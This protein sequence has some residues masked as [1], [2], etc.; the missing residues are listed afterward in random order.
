MTA[1]LSVQQLQHQLLHNCSAV[2]QLAAL[3][4]VPGVQRRYESN[5]EAYPEYN[6]PSPY[7]A[8]RGNRRVHNAKIFTGGV[9][10]RPTGKSEDRLLRMPRWD[11]AKADAWTSKKALFGQ[12]DYIDILGDGTLHPWELIKAPY[13]LKG[14]RGNELQRIARQ[15]AAEGTFIRDVYPSKYH[16]MTKNLMYLY[17]KLNRR[18]HSEL[19]GRYRGRGRID[20]PGA[21]D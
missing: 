8:R 13:W 16:Q 20:D 10:P 3:F 11:P 15:L 4:G 17:K 1:I 9:L 6:T 7:K 2:R 21:A 12:N 5:Y 18:Q 19:W 14:F